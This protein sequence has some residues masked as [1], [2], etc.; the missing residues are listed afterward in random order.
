MIRVVM[1]NAGFKQWLRACC[2]R[3]GKYNYDIHMGCGAIK[4]VNG[5]EISVRKICNH[6]GEYVIWDGVHFTEASNKFIYKRFVKGEFS[7]PAVPLRRSCH[8]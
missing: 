4:F 7:D 3:G 5:K 6:P 8:T 2:G 1:Y